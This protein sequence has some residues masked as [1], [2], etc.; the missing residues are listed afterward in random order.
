M[1]IWVRLPGLP[2]EFYDPLTIKEVTNMIDPIL[3]IDAQT[4]FEVQ[5]RYAR[6]V[7]SWI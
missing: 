1:A 7:F 6:F 5:E 4:T 3:K 2:M